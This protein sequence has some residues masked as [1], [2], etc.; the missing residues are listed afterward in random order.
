M[1]L[2]DILWSAGQRFVNL[3]R[4]L[5]NWRGDGVHSPYAFDFIRQ[6]IRNPH[7]YEA[8]RELYDKALAERWAEADGEEHY[9]LKPS[10]LELAFR[11][12]HRHAPQGIYIH[13]RYPEAC[14]ADVR[15][16]LSEY[17]VATGYR[18]QVAKP[19]EAELIVVENVLE[20]LELQLSEK[21]R[22]GCMVLINTRDASVREW[23]RL[24]RK[25]LA[26]PIIFE[27]VGME[28][29]VWRAGTTPGHYPVY[30]K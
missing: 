28:I 2:E 26:P 8:Y 13:S 29:W 19:Q 3:K 4:R 22:Q 25:A 17:L 12:T 9:I 14:R 20:P 1:S 6:V 27:V 15:H 23:L 21:Q 24:V 7:P 5:C 18:Q 11:A 16:L 30:Y 10:L